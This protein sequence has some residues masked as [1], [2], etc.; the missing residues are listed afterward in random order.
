MARELKGVFVGAGYFSHFHLDAWNR[1]PNVQIVAGCDLDQDK[2]S[3]LTTKYNI[4]VSYKSVEEMLDK[5]NP[6]FIDII[7]PPDTHLELCKLA[8]SKGVHMLCQKP[9]APT[10]DEATHLFDLVNKSQ[11]RFMVHDNWRFQ[12]WYRKVKAL[13]DQ[14]AIGDFHTINFR[15]RMGDGWG[16]D[17]YL[18]RQPYFRTMERL[19]IHETGVHFIDAFRYLFGDINKVYARLRRLNPV[20]KGEDTGWVQFDF[21]HG[22]MGLLDAGRYNETTAEKPRFTFGEALIEG[23]DGSIRIYNDGRLTLTKLG[24]QEKDV[25]YHIPQT[26]FCGDSV[27]ACLNHFISCLV[28]GNEFETSALDYQKT[29]EVQEAIYRS[30]REEK[31]VMV[32]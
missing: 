29:L 19:L 20:I 7:T 14:K 24:Q 8:I 11:V 23:Y 16:E 3:T 31:G 6:D 5:E 10:F 17:A 1:I 30:S 22:G 28:D 26:G 13:M 25:S 12:P 18:G 15:M 27:H 9:V 21:A 32:G 2:L 4:P